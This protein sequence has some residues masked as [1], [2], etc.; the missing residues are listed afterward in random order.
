MEE[1]KYEFRLCTFRKLCKYYYDINPDATTDY[2]KFYKE[3][4]GA[5]ESK[6]LLKY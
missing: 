5:E 6:T 2:I 3:M 4:K 1:L